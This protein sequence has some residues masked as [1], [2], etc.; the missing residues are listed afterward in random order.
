MP[1]EGAKFWRG[2][3][4]KDLEIIGRGLC[5]TSIDKKKHDGGPR[6][7]GPTSSTGPEVPTQFNNKEGP[8]TI[9]IRDPRCGIN[10]Y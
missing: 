6:S 3:S 2:P 4:L 8:H 7:P 9:I 10:E 5:G 1:E